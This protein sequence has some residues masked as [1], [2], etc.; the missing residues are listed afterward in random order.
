[1]PHRGAVSYE[2]AP[3]WRLH[4]CE[5]GSSITEPERAT[6]TE[7]AHI[8]CPRPASRLRV[9]RAAPAE[10]GMSLRRCADAA[11]WSSAAFVPLR[12]LRVAVS[13]PGA[14]AALAAS[15]ASYVMLSDAGL[16]VVAKL[17][18]CTHAS[19]R[20]AANGAL[21]CASLRKPARDGRQCCGRW[22]RSSSGRRH[23]SRRPVVCS[24]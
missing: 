3:V 18:V 5:R 21:I 7:R 19:R 10:M 12:S 4:P 14:G 20:G 17:N 15:G 11:A 8:R 16:S 23:I 2:L 22:T 13:A 24:R 6:E 9:T 1:M